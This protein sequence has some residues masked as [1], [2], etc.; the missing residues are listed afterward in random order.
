[1]L[2][3]CG[4]LAPF[5]PDDR[6]ISLRQVPRCHGG[7]V[8]LRAGAGSGHN[9]V[10]KARIERGL[11]RQKRRNRVARETPRVIQIEFSGFHA[12]VDVPVDDPGFVV[13]EDQHCE[14]AERDFRHC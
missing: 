14:D 5:V 10:S 2:A 9:R 13:P 11:R 8:G 6:R 1:M 12:A 3:S 7:C 4:Y